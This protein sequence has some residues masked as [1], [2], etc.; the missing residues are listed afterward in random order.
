MTREDVAIKVESVN[1]KHP[2]L[3]F[4][5]RVYMELAGQVGIPFMHCFGIEGSHNAKA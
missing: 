2:Q 4:D 1:E 5:S 3:D